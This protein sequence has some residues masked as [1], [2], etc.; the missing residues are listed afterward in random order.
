MFS[1]LVAVKYLGVYNAVISFPEGFHEKHYLQKIGTF[2]HFQVRMM[3][4]G[5]NRNVE[6]TSV[7]VLEILKFV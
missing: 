7:F 5:I 4:M 1:F 6:D 3:M 2:S